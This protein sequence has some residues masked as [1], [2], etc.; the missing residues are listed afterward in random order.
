[1]DYVRVSVHFGAYM[2]VSTRLFTVLDL[3]GREAERLP[4]VWGRVGTWERG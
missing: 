2:L 3:G 1:M 4:P